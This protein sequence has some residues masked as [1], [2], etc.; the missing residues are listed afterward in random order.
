[1]TEGTEAAPA[2]A[3]TA[4]AVD[5]KPDATAITAAV[6]PDA[7]KAADAG[8]TIESPDAK[9][10]VAKVGAPEKYEVFTLKEGLVVDQPAMDSFMPI[11]KE[12]NLTQDQAQKLVDFQSE[13]VQQS[14]KA[15]HEA[16]DTLLAD[17]VKG[18]KADIEIGGLGF[19]DAVAHAG[20]A[21]KVF[22]TPELKAALDA[23]GV[24]NHPEFIRVFARIGKAISE[25][26][27]HFG[28]AGAATEPKSLAERLFPDQGKAQGA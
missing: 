14:V 13:L 1:M 19:N 4:A 3:I 6:A 22:G 25:D 15:E 11:A 8:K 23:T 20:R 16:W 26:K 10:D 12:L 18:A 24:G 5:V 27:L 2:S 17:W 28:N 21:I 7:A 9:S